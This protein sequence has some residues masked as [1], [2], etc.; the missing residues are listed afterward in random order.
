MKNF[1]IVSLFPAALLFGHDKCFMKNEWTSSLYPPFFPF[2]FF[3][4]SNICSIVKRVG[5]NFYVLF[6]Y[7]VHGSISFLH[8]L[9]VSNFYYVFWLH[10][11]LLLFFFFIFIAALTSQQFTKKQLTL[12]V[13]AILLDFLV[14]IIQQY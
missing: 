9:T 13:S 1:V 10:R 8:S 3:V 6:M 5:E 14:S 7:F 12:W 11:V 2:I 4:L